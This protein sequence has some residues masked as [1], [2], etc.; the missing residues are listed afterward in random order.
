MQVTRVEQQLTVHVQIL[1]HKEQ[2]EADLFVILSNCVHGT[3]FDFKVTSTNTAW[4]I[5]KH[6]NSDNIMLL[7]SH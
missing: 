5:S 3:N 4:I 6:A 7:S 1:L 2:C